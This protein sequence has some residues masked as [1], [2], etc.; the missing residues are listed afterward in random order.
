MRKNGSLSLPGGTKFG[1]SIKV[2]KLFKR[3]LENMH[4]LDTTDECIQYHEFNDEL[5][6]Q[7][8]QSDREAFEESSSDFVKK[9]LAKLD[10]EHVPAYDSESMD[11][12]A[13]SIRGNLL[14][15]KRIKP[16]HCTEC[17]RV[18][19]NADTLMLLFN[20]KQNAAFWKCA[21]CEDMKFKR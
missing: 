19:D 9:V 3:K 1:N 4:L 5:P 6:I 17:D 18:H 8:N 11:I 10:T 16:S 14:Y 2:V 20:E 15:V 12:Y 21:H 13:N 7:A